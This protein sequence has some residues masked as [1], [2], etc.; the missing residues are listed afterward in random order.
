MADAF[1]DAERLGARDVRTTIAHAR[2]V[3]GDVEYDATAFNTLVEL[4]YI[5]RPPGDESYVSGIPSLM[6]YVRDRALDAARGEFVPKAGID[7][8]RSR[9]RSRDPLQPRRH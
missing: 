5:W 3:Q 6:G 7:A 4:G 2:P 1:A 8:P 9:T